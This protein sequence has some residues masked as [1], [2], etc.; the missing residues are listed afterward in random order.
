LL[1]CSGKSRANTH[2]DRSPI[3]YD[4]RR[5]RLHGL[6]E[7]I[8]NTHRYRVTA[9]GLRTALFYTRL[10]TRTMR[11]ALAIISPADANPGFPMANTIRAAEAAL[12]TWHRD[13]K[14]A[15]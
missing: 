1:P 12:D 7:R 15:A 9:K 8:P 5:L 13:A 11:P 6:T 2:R 4:L 10:Y 14:I 3:T